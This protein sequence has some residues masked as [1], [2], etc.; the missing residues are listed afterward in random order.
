MRHGEDC[1][2]MCGLKQGVCP[3]C[4]SYGACCMRNF[5]EAPSECMHGQ[6][7]CDDFHC[8]VSM[9]SSSAALPTGGAQQLLPPAL[10]EFKLSPEAIVGIAIGA[11]AASLLL[12]AMAISLGLWCNRRREGRYG[13]VIEGL[14]GELKRL[15]GSSSSHRHGRSILSQSPPETPPGSA[16]PRLN[17][18][19]GTL[20]LCLSRSERAARAKEAEAAVLAREMLALQKQEAAMVAAEEA[21]LAAEEAAFEAELA[22][23]ARVAAGFGGR[24]STAANF[25]APPSVY[26]RRYRYARPACGPCGVQL[27]AGFNPAAMAIGAASPR[28]AP[29]SNAALWEQLAEKNFHLQRQLRGMGVSLSGVDAFDGHGGAARTPPSTAQPS[30]TEEEP[31]ECVVPLVQDHGADNTCSPAAPPPAAPATTDETETAESRPS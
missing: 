10:A 7:G 30:L 6:L 31:A 11:T 14:E 24:A 20:P 19:I 5:N 29:H 2:V 4:G 12:L 27:A 26:G 9:S 13:E 23:E 22:A 16:S 18:T 21:E 25:G 8:C 1:W 28:L 3:A 15:K 17:A